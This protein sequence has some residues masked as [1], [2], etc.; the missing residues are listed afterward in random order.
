MA[1]GF[2]KLYDKYF[3]DDALNNPLT[4]MKESRLKSD[5][6]DKEI[7]KYYNDLVSSSINTRDNIVQ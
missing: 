6:I 2:Q 7:E 5:S 4:F 3:G 1:N